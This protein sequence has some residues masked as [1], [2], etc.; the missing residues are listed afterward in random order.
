MYKII[1]ADQKEYG[2][3][4]AD[5]IRQWIAEGRAN[6]ETPIQAAGMA[7]WRPLSLYPEFAAALASSPSAVMPPL[8]SASAGPGA[9][10]TPEEIL[11]RD[12][13]VDIGGYI[14]R[15]WELTKG[16]FF[17]VV[18]I[19]FL[20]L[21]MPGILNQIIGLIYRPGLNE[22]MRSQELS[23]PA[24]L[25][26]FACMLVMMPIQTI[27]IGG[28]YK[29]YIKMVR[30]ENPDLGV[31]FSTIGSSFGQLALLGLVMGLFMLLGFCLCIIPAIYMGVSWIF[32]IPLVVDRQMGFWQAMELSR[33][34]VGRHWFMMLA[35]IIVMGLVRI[36]GLF[37]CCIGIFVTI[38]IGWLA[39]MCVYEDIFGR[40]S[41]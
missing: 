10:P 26:I 24:I 14:N 39:L 31:V 8:F 40:R 21:L 17:P 38:P 41:Q 30:G 34:A 32:A 16:N 22:M 15:G 27:F 13:D 25:L 29:Y 18:G 23:G 35:F 11:A 33:K 6:G 37:A 7:E 12:Y 5:D 19:T 2:P 1:G 3:V 20:V 28:L 4:S 36:A 9:V